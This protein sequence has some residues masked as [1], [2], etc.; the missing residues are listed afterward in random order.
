[1]SIASNLDYS[2]F[3]IVQEKRKN[4]ELCAKEE[5]FPGKYDIVTCSSGNI[6][7]AVHVVV[8]PFAAFPRSPGWSRGIQA[9]S[10]GGG[11]N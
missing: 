9:G 6:E 5:Y 10:G 11:Y 1:V 2:L 4:I 7:H 8:G 3:I